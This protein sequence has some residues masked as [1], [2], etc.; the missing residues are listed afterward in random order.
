MKKIIT[1]LNPDLDAVASVWLIK[2]FLPDWQRAIVD[3]VPST[4]SALD[5][6]QEKS[7]DILYVDVGGGRLDHH[8]TAEF[9]SATSLCLQYIEEKKG[10]EEKFSPLDKEALARLVKVVT[11]IDNARVLEW[12]EVAQ[13]R[14]EFYLHSLISGLRG[15]GDSDQQVIDFSLKALDSIF[16][17]LKSKI[18]AQQEL[19]QGIKFET[20]WGPAVAYER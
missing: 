14:S 11:Q 5:R 12:P 15:L 1:H 6:N 3:F 8:Q 20:P 13:D 17:N 7:N 4:N 10:I 9:L 19:K 16:L 18:R 2:R